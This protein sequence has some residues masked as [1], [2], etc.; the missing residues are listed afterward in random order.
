MVY[1]TL[2]HPDSQDSLL[3]KYWTHDRKVVSSNPGRGSGT[4]FFSRVNF[5]CW[6]LFCVHSTPMLPQWHAEDP[7]HSAKSTGG[8]LHLDT[9]K[10]LAQQSWCGLTMPLSRYS[11][12][13]YLETSSHA[14][15]LGTFSHSCLSSL[16]HCGLI[17]AQRMELACEI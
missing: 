9:H 3:V 4:I 15:C 1:I 6:L 17:L 16:S 8:R 2:I 5:V 14:T 11:L 13:A 12:G 7:G 10:P